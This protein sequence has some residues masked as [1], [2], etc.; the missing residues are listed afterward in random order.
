MSYNAQKEAEDIVRDLSLFS[1]ESELIAYITLKLQTAAT[2]GMLDQLD[3]ETKKLDAVR[4][5][6]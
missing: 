6:E 5:E 4:G 1:N 2:S 3:K